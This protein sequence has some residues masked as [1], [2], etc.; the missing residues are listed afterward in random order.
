MSH[1]DDYVEDLLILLLQDCYGVGGV[2][3]M[4]VRKHWRLERCFEGSAGNRKIDILHCVLYMMTF[5]CL[6]FTERRWCS[7]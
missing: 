7:G 6:L 4:Q 1:R 2:G 5:Y 3:S